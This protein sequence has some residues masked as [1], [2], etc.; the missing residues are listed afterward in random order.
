MPATAGT[1]R[2]RALSAALRDARLTN[3]MGSRELARH[4]E[5]S[6]T[7]I[8]H[9]E[10][11]HR[12]PNVET[13]AMILTALRVSPRERERILDLARNVA[14]PNWLT[15]G[16]NGIPQQL[17]GVVECERSASAIV[18]WSPMVIPGLLQTSDYTRAIKVAAQLSHTDVELRVMLNVSRREVITQ[19]DPVS[20]HAVI[21]EGGLYEPIGPEGV[22]LDQLR[23]LAEMTVRPNV[24]V[25]LMPQRI[26]WH[27]GWAGPFVFYEFPDTSPVVHF[28]HHSSGA[29]IPTEHD[30]TEYKKAVSWLR[31]IAMDE[32]D[33]LAHIEK[34]IS[35]WEEK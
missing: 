26:G 13:V 21:G 4:L 6:H 32:A 16:M 9:W 35:H 24:V 29:F 1:P 14:E 3:G 5:L 25:Q 34:A 31:D 2:A 20:F 11:G 22:M 27:P 15:V 8:S 7:Q 18:E 30:V 19:R 10:N 12:V 17:A 33:S 23:H 28:E